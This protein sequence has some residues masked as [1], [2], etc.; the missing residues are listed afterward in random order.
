MNG[1]TVNILP[2]FII[3]VFAASAVVISGCANVAE[4]LQD[5]RAVFLSGSDPCSA[6]REPFVEVRERQRE[7]I[8]K[9]TAAGAFA[10]AVAVIKSGDADRN[11]LILGTL[12]GGLAGAVTGY[13]YNLNKRAA[14][15]KDLRR[16]IFTDAES[17]A[18]GGDKLVATVSR[19][20]ACRLKSLDDIVAAVQSGELGKDEA[21]S[22]LAAVKKQTEN[23]NKLIASVSKGLT[24]RSSVYV[25]ALQLSGDDNVD[26]FIEEA[27]AYKPIVQKPRYAISRAPSS[28]T[29]TVTFSEAPLIESQDRTR[30]KPAVP[31]SI[32]TAVVRPLP[33]PITLRKR[34]ISNENSVT[35]TAMGAIELDAMVIAHVESVDEAIDNIEAVLL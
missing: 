5:S 21:R 33:S 9:W 6:S 28:Q 12:A 13:Y 17:D 18:K 31:S 20:N 32:E 8:F 10:G 15:T 30:A 16:T 2:K 29:A 24:K 27:E 1:C 35:A 7:Q 11:K 4:V 14:T 34:A 22:R 26:R 19:L 3:A 23:D 25:S